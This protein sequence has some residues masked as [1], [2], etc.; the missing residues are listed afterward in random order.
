M[1]NKS[2]KVKD[3]IKDTGTKNQLFVFAGYNPNTTISDT[4]ESSINLWDYSDF[5]VRIGQNSILP[6]VSYIEWIQRR[7]YMPWS[8]TKP[9]TG[10]FYAYNKQNG[11]VYLCI[12]DNTQNRID[13]SGR[14]VSTIRPSH[15][16]GIQAYSDGYSWKPLYKITPSIERFVTSS[17]LPVISF[18][19]YD[20]TQQVTQ[21]LLTSSFCSGNNTGT[22][23][24]CAIYAKI[25]L[26]TDDDAGTT[27]YAV[28]DLFTIA[29]DITCSD[30]HYLMYNNEKF[31]SVFYGA[32]ETVPST[33]TIQDKYSLVGSKITSNEIS[34]SSPF[35]YLY[36]INENDGVAEG[37]VISAF[38]DLSG[39][40][41]TDLV[42]SVQNPE[43]T[44]SSNTGFDARIRLTTTL[45][46]DSYVINGIEVINPGYGYKDIKLS[47]PSSTLPIDEALIINSISVNLD[48]IDGIGFDPVDI[49]NAQ[50]AMIDARIE[51]KTLEDSGINILDKLNFFGLIQNPVSATGNNEI[52]TGSNKNK[53]I[54]VI[55]RTTILATI[56]S[57]SAGTLPT[58][59]QIYNT[60]T[61]QTPSPP[62]VL[63][64]PGESQPQI[65]SNL[66]GIL[67]GGTKAITGQPT[68]IQAELK[69][70]SYTKANFLTGTVL[71]SINSTII[72]GV[73][74]SPEFKQ[75]SGK[76]LTTKKLNNE[77]DLS[78]TDSVIIR[79]NNVIGM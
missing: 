56:S 79:I 24:Q 8:S 61:G 18:E 11:Y 76:I 51:K 2:V 49:L 45:Y 30:C 13:H 66:N 3:F 36:Q 35:Y 73:S 6:V 19:L 33:I 31:V 28:G 59:G 63:D 50:H 23:G 68:K 65:L 32:S 69:N 60:S 12:S 34:T 77:L 37:A 4:N 27:E 26:N 48:R 70:V 74:A 55:Y 7:P 9:N 62:N 1:N 72:N 78:N 52:V 64:E 15:T 16:S 29:D 44:I 53:K 43:L 67:I 57:S 38:I 46:Q 58:T 39:F 54:D 40:N 21:E 25:P 5:S 17:W 75:Y 20:S 71:N 10:N 41:S 14:T 42:T 22:L 47:L